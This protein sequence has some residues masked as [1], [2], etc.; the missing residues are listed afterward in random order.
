MSTPIKCMICMDYI[1]INTINSLVTECGHCFHTNCLMKNVAHNGFACP[2]CCTVMAE[3]YVSDDEE[4]YLRYEEEV[5]E[6]ALRGFRFFW[7]NLYGETYDKDDEADE[8]LYYISTCIETNK[9]PSNNYIAQILREQ[10]L[11]YE[12]ILYSL[13][14]DNEESKNTYKNII[15]RIYS[16]LNNY[17]PHNMSL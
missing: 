14:G 10:G 1:N 11:T 13:Q 12:Q 5:K 3:E 17:T 2:C 4:S 9:G 15:E 6:D 16:I 8:N 7:N